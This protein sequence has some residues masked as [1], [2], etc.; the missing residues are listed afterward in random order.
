MVLMKARRGVE[1]AKAD[2]ELEARFGRRSEESRGRDYS[3]GNCD[4]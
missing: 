3:N 1:A 4:Q 2:A